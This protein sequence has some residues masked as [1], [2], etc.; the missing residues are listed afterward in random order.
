MAKTVCRKA[1]LSAVLL[2]ALAVSAVGDNNLAVGYY[3]TICP[4]AEAIV[5]GVVNSAFQNFSGIAAKLIRLHFHDCFVRGCDGSVLLDSIPG[6][7]V[8]EKDFP[9]SNPS[10]GGFEVIDTAKSLLEAVCPKLVSC[11]DIVAFAAR[12]SALLASPLLHPLWWD[13]PAGR[14]DGNTSLSSDILENMPG[15]TSNVTQLTQMFAAKGL[16]QDEMV[17]LSGAHT[18]GVSHCSIFASRLYNFSGS[19]TMDPSLDPMYVQVLKQN[20]TRPNTTTVFM[21]PETPFILDNAY[22]NEV[23]ANR[24]LFTSD[25]TLLTDPNTKSSVTANSGSNVVEWQKA[26]AAAMVKMGNIGVLTD[27]EGEV[28][29]NCRVANG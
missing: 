3:N 27:N 5:F 23:L 22:Y 13:A 19:N 26:F 6:Q 25:A 24:G 11:A 29:V 14:K 2:C 16:S 28:R 7:F 8:A 20:C 4:A 18:I 17:T 10:L 12:D 9:V 1:M 21:D 15:P